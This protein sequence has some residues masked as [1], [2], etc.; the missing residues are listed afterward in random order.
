MDWA[1]N[2]QLAVS[3]Q[4]SR[5]SLTP[6]P[7]SVDH[8]FRSRPLHP[9]Q[10]HLKHIHLREAVQAGDKNRI[11]VSPCQERRARG[12]LFPSLQF[13]KTVITGRKTTTPLFWG[14]G[15]RAEP[16]LLSPRRWAR[17]LSLWAGLRQKPCPRPSTST[18]P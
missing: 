5:L 15:S 16:G 12:S 17:C 11:R 7:N 9:R 10:N 8:V 6:K 18:A 3:G 2:A 13:P 14:G 4:V 1:H